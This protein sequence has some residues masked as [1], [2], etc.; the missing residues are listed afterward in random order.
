MAVQTCGFRY[1]T[2]PSMEAARSG[3]NRAVRVTQIW[4]GENIRKVK[5]ALTDQTMW[6]DCTP[7]AFTEVEHV[8]MVEVAMEDRL[9]TRVSQQFLQCLKALNQNTPMLCSGSFKVVEPNVQRNQIGQPF[10]TLAMQL[11][12]GS[13]KN[14]ASVIVFSRTSHIRQ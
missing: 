12:S 11:I 10:G 2:Q 7:A 4:I 5:A 6:V 13:T 1:H 9:L 8:V 3:S 14:A